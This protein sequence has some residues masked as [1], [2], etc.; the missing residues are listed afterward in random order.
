MTSP[1]SREKL[2]TAF[3]A[4]AVGKKFRVLDPFLR[5]Y[6]T[7]DGTTKDASKA[8]VYDGKFD[9]DTELDAFIRQ[10]CRAVDITEQPAG[11]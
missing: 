6:W 11:A 2:K 3:A 10:G 8:R 9:T 5:E 1:E 7:D 4:S